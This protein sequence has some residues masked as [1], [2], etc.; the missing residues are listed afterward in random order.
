MYH[1]VLYFIYITSVLSFYIALVLTF[2]LLRMAIPIEMKWNESAFVGYWAHYM[3][4]T[5]DYALEFSRSKFD[6]N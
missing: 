5:H 6:I 1:K 4:F 2:F 3:A